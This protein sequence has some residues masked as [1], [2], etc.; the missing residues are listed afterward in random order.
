VPKEAVVELSG[1]GEEQEEEL[2]VEK[3]I[4]DIG[5]ARELRQAVAPDAR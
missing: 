4:S 5:I 3:E 1:E 2:G